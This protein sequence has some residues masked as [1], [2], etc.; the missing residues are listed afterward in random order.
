MTLMVFENVSK[1]VILKKCILKMLF[2]GEMFGRKYFLR[3]HF[4]N[5]FLK[6]IFWGSNFKNIFWDVTF[7]QTVLK[8]YFLRKY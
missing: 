3:E 5:L 6:R 1:R 7:D 2:W 8:M 4:E